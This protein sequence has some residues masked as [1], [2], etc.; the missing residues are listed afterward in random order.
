MDI[1]DIS[2][3]INKK[4][5]SPVDLVQYNLQVID[6]KNPDINAFI[7]VDEEGALEQAKIL[8]KEAANGNIRGPL[9]GIQIA[10]KDLIFTKDMKTTMG[11]KMYEEFIPEVDATVIK[12]LKDAGAIIIG[13]LNTH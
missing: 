12:K 7:T 13:K 5:L 10:V 2:A 1:T 11:S 4:E 6:K 3:L 9:H 8:E